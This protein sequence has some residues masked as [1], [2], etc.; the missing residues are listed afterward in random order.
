MTRSPGV[1][2]RFVAS[3]SASGAAM[4]LVAESPRYA[5]TRPTAST[6][7]ARS[8]ECTAMRAPTPTTLT[9]T[10]TAPTIARRR[11]GSAPR[12]TVARP[13]SGATSRMT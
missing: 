13:T 6:G 1:R 10:I 2:A 8:A 9:S 3:M 4:A 5:V 12:A 11:E 7:K